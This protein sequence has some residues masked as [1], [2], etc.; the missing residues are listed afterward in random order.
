[1]SE[2]N[3]LRRISVNTLPKRARPPKTA[4]KPPPPLTLADFE[5]GKALGKGKLG[6][7]YCAKHKKSGFICAIKV[8]AKHDLVLLRLK[9]NFQREIEIQKGL[10]HQQI[11]RLYGFFS[12]KPTCT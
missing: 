7:V 11:S 10:V 2:T 8:M 1:M 4:P 6:K 12:I 3:P 5:I 9:A